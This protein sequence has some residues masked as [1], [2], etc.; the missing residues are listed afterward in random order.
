MGWTVIC[1]DENGEVVAEFGS[2][3][4]FTIIEPFISKH[5]GF[6]LL[7]YLDLYGDTVFNHLQLPDL[8]TDLEKLKAYGGSSKVIDELLEL[9]AICEEGDHLYLKF[10][11]D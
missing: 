10:Y 11:G 8:R 6:Q 4:D 5:L 7:H 3:L 2:E 1:E 9:V